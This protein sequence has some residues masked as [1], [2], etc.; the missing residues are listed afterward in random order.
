MKVLRCL[1]CKQQAIVSD[2]CEGYCSKC[3]MQLIYDPR[4]TQDLCGKDNEKEKRQLEK[5]SIRS[6]KKKVK[7]YKKIK[8]RKKKL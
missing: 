8:L 7:V 1:S 5:Q 2:G 3:H 6:A 4:L